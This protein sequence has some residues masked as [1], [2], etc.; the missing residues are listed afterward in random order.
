MG[1]K[2]LIVFLV[3]IIVIFLVT[4]LI[5]HRFRVSFRESPEF[6]T[7]ENA[8]KNKKVILELTDGIIEFEDFGGTIVGDSAR[9]DITLQGKNKS[10]NAT[11][12]LIKKD[13]SWEIKSHEIF[14][15]SDNSDKWIPVPQ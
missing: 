8:I 2:I 4:P 15:K 10:I 7:A 3:F 12:Y 13:T 5:Y 6:R 11:Y 14:K 1:K 9:I